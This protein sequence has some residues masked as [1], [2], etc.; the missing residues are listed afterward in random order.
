MDKMDKFD[1]IFNSIVVILGVFVVSFCGYRI[2]TDY[3]M[4]DRLIY[5]FGGIIWGFVTIEKIIELIREAIDE[6]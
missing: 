4:A 3:L 1:K 2:Y 6:N 5:Y